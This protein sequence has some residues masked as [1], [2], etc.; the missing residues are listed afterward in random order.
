[1]WSGGQAVAAMA[2]GAAAQATADAVPTATLAGLC[3][4]V[5]AAAARGPRL[6]PEPAKAAAED[7]SPARRPGCRTWP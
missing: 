3:L 4:L 5:S 1:A 6:P 2:A 7:T